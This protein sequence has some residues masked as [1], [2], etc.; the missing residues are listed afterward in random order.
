M[1]VRPVRLVNAHRRKEFILAIARRATL[2]LVASIVALARRGLLAQPSV[3]GRWQMAQ[4][5][6]VTLKVNADC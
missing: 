5:R 6:I 4:T 1:L 3:Q 2:V